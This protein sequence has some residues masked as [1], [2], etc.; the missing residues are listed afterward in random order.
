[1]LAIIARYH[2]VN[3]IHRETMELYTL[4]TITTFA[5]M[6]D[7]VVSDKKAALDINKIFDGKINFVTFFSRHVGHQLLAFFLCVMY[8]EALCA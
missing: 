5:D 1:M 7:S 4:E 8:K 2:K 3:V 6:R